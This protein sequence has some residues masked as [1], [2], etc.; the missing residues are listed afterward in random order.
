M[1][2]EF[3]VASGAAR[4]NPSMAMMQTLDLGSLHDASADA[5][6]AVAGL[7]LEHSN[8]HHPKVGLR[9]KRGTVRSYRVTTTQKWD[10]AT[11]GALSTLSRVS[12]T[13]PSAG[14]P[15][16]PSSRTL[17]GLRAAQ[18]ATTHPPRGAGAC[19]ECHANAGDVEA[20]CPD[21]WAER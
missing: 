19:L 2:R 17:S 9:H 3:M 4:T 5:V 21:G 7:E 20:G 16:R 1:V 8:N 6:A 11:S 13:T 15:L 18:R 12:L 14:L 10:F